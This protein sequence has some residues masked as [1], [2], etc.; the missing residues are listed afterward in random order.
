MGRQ[1][2]PK[3]P[4]GAGVLILLRERFLVW[5]TGWGGAESLPSCSYRLPRRERISS[6]GITEPRPRPGARGSPL[7]HSVRADGPVLQRAEGWQ[8]HCKHVAALG[9]QVEQLA[10]GVWQDH[11][12]LRGA[13]G[14]PVEG[15]DGL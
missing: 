12:D 6:R 14:S 9:A 7:Q 4:F 15:K 13:G 2:A 5:G 1:V 8:L 11:G 10:G 3:T